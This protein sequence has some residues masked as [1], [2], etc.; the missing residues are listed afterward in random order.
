MF[1]QANL[2][3]ES[4]ADYLERHPA[5]IGEGTGSKFLTTGDPLRVSGH[6]T[7][8]LRRLVSFEAA[9]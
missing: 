1:S 4:L 9:F 8:F 3:A 6:A 5:M 7:N 2:V